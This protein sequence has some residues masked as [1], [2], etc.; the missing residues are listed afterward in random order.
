VNRYYHT[1]TSRAFKELLLSVAM[2]WNALRQSRPESNSRSSPSIMSLLPA[3]PPSPD[4]IYPREVDK[5]GRPVVENGLRH[6]VGFDQIFA[7]KFCSSTFL[8]YRKNVPRPRV[9]ARRGC[10]GDPLD[11]ARDCTLR[12]YGRSFFS[13]LRAMILEDLQ[14]AN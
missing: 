4:E 12:R 6:L 5:L 13:H 11:E 14:I 7:C 9:S 1:R 3:S 8:T 10:R 2:M